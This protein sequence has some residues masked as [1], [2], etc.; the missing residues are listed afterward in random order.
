MNRLIKIALVL[1]LAFISGCY[2]D[3]EER[4]YPNTFSPCDDVTSTFAHTVT[5]ILQPCR[6][7]H[8]NSEASSSGKGIKLENYADIVTMV[9]NGKLMGSIRHENG[10]SAMPQGGGKLMDCEISQLQAWIDNGT[11]NN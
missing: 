2:Y 8:S 1:A 7:C 5:P 11:L 9:K 3:T 6:S 10:F 4:L